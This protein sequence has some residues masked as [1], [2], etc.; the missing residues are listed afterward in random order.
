M[1]RLK[2]ISNWKNVSDYLPILN[3]I[4]FVDLAGIY[5]F[6]SG[7]IYSPSLV[8]WYRTYRLSAVIADVL[9][10]FIGFV[11]A[12]LAFPYLFKSYSLVAFTFVAVAIQVIHDFSFYGF[13]LAFPK[14]ANKMIDTFKLYSKHSG[15]GAVIG[16]STMVIASC[17]IAAWLATYSLNINI[18]VFVFLF[19]FLQYF[20]YTY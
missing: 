14:N 8:E 12:R 13:V 2:D 10:I 5:L 9:V 15:I 18:I 4:L 11:L 17:F 16:D 7:I 19:Y 1:F 3:A 6:N 20:L